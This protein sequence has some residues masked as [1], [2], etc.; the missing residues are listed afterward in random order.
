MGIVGGTLGYELLRR[1]D[2][3]GKSADPAPGQQF[4][5]QSAAYAGKSKT[6]V[7]FGP[8]I[9]AEV[10]G[11]LAIDF[12]CADGAEA[13]AMAKHGARRVIG[14]DTRESVLEIARRAAEAAGVADRC[15][16]STRT[17]ERADVIFSIDWFEHHHDPAA[18]LAEMR[19]LLDDAGRVHISFGPA[20]YHPMGGHLFSVFPWSHL[21]F[22]ERAL[23]RWRS[24][25]KTDGATRF[26]EVEGGLNQMTIGRFERLLAQSA[27]RVE[28]FET[29]PIKKLRRFHNRLTREFFSSYVRCTLAPARGN[30]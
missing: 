14:I 22:T 28:R 12:G 5:W 19:R 20:W 29:P 6:E 4:P 18:L 7:L 11:K 10:E 8:G 3:G 9:W 23:I 1:I 26:H 17:D 16:F 13:I 25:F 2:P 24:D 21:I 15:S 30:A 27:F